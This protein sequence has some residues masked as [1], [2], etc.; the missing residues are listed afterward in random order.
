M[1]KSGLS[2]ARSNNSDQKTGKIL[3]EQT[4]GKISDG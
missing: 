1:T 4:K 2:E 3:D